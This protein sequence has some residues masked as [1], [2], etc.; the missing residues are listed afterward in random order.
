MRVL[1]R[2]SLCAV[3]AFFLLPS[4]MVTVQAQAPATTD[5]L[6]KPL[7]QYTI[8]DVF[9][10]VA[11]DAFRETG[12]SWQAAS[13]EFLKRAGDRRAALGTAIPAKET[14]I[15]SLKEQ[16]KAANKN[17][18]FTK[19][20]TLEGQIKTEEIVT[21]VLGQLSKLNDSQSATATAWGEAGVAMQ[22]FVDADEKFDQYRTIGIARPEDGATGQRLTAEGYN[23]TLAQAQAMSDMGDAF[24]KVGSA[25]GSLADRRKA[26]L[27]SLAKGGHIEK[28]K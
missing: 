17:K 7:T 22:K 16:L 27:D 6:T 10:K 18:D 3:L 1:A 4:V 14:E 5:N 13:N 19:A 25:L 23:A 26:L 21:A 24:G 8:G 28:P 2:L 15:K 11:G 9:P 12:K 20:G